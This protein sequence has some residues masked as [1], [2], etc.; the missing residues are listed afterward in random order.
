MK[1][2]LLL[3]LLSVGLAVVYVGFQ[4]TRFGPDPIDYCSTHHVPPKTDAVTA[5]W[6]WVPPSWDCLYARIH[7]QERSHVFLRRRA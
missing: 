3:G 7:E 1:W 4:L 5:E 2:F 6:S